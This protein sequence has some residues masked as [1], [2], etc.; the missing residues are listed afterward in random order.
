MSKL[1]LDIE[2]M[3]ESFFADTALIGMASALPG[4]RFCW[5]LN[6]YLDMQFTRRADMDV[7]LQ[8]TPAQQYYFAIYRHVMPA[9]GSQYLLYKL[10][11]DKESLL[12]EVKQLDYLWMI[13]SSTP[14]ADAADI[15][16]RLRDLPDVLLAQVL[17]PQ[18]MK[19]LGNLLV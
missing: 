10:K 9:H 19:N 12:P 8:I 16:R 5:M 6:H 2:A 18:R 11:S 14:D 15:T 4:H 3:Q 17:Q 7:R 1:T 13:Q